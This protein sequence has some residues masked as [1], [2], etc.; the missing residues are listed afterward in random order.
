LT[1]V[2]AVHIADPAVSCYKLQFVGIA[3]ESAAGNR[4]E[5]VVGPH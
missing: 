1:L 5:L 4:R 2:A 3:I